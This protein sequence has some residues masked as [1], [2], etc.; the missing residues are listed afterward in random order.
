MRGQIK[1]KSMYF[2]TGSQP[3]FSCANISGE[4]LK[5]FVTWSF[6]CGN[7]LRSIS[8]LTGPPHVDLR[9]NKIC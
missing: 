5:N 4:S 9:L 2:V 3:K 7:I 8:H 1:S 6:N